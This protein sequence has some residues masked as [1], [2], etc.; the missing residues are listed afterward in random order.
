[1]HPLI[2][3]FLDLSKAAAA[4]EKGDRGTPLDPEEAAF[5]AAAKDDAWAA[6]QIRKA[7]GRKTPPTE[8][9]HAQIL[10][11]T[12]A[13]AAMV[14]ADATLGPKVKRAEAALL[15]EGATREAAD[16]LITMAVLE[17]AFGYAEAP[18]HFDVAYL[19]ETFD[20]LLA[21]ATVTSDTVD[22]LLDGFA[23]QA[24]AQKVLRLRVAEALF[25]A[26]WNEGPVPVTPEHVDDAL[27]SLGASEAQQAGEQ[28]AALLA[29]LAAKGLVGPQRLGRLTAI[30]KSAAAAGS[31]A[32][33]DEDAEEDE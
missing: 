19:S 1:M 26:A 31:D 3:R 20:T 6:D 12:E 16:R 29:F 13:A 5:Y 14:S 25:E 15:A 27:D 10:L 23:K 17:E 8:A 21:L 33:D 4:L 9:Q 2:A 30:V 22:D 18:D 24:P 32:D 7:R 28:L 11:A